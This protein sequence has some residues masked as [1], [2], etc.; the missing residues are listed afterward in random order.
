[1]C[2]AGSSSCVSAGKP[3]MQ[4]KEPGQRNG[5]SASFLCL[6]SSVLSFPFRISRAAQFR[7]VKAGRACQTRFASSPRRLLSPPDLFSGI[8]RLSRARLS[9]SCDGQPISVRGQ[10]QTFHCH[11]KFCDCKM[12]SVGC[13]SSFGLGHSSFCDAIRNSETRS[14]I[15]ELEA[16]SSYGKLNRSSNDQIKLP[17][18]R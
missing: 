1:M 9:H 17:M 18:A 16:P 4:A 10:S 11:S 8:S 13:Q 7:G 2:F 5:V 12:D 14:D 3:K 6:H 15:A